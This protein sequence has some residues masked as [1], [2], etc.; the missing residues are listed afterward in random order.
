MLKYLI[1]ALDDLRSMTL[2]EQAA[3]SPTNSLH[4]FGRIAQQRNLWLGEGD[5]EASAQV[6]L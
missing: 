1:T 2:R 3:N 4:P 5:T 6:I